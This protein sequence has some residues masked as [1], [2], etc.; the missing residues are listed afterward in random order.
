MN[1]SD[2]YIY[3]NSF[4]NV[5][6]ISFNDK[7]N[8][9]EI[10]YSSAGLLFYTDKQNVNFAKFSGQISGVKSV[11]LDCANFQFNNKELINIFPN[12]FNE[13]IHSIHLISKGC[14][15]FKSS[16]KLFSDHYKIQK[17][18][19]CKCKQKKKTKLI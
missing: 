12:Y 13:E 16:L 17:D 11:K 5:R 4:D 19:R 1:A 10:K 3:S 8:L 2:H 15:R 14:N 18:F 7:T 6:E 9:I